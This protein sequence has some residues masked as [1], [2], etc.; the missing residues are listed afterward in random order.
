MIELAKV[1]QLEIQELILMTVYLL[2]LKQTCHPIVRIWVTENCQLFGNV[3]DE[4]LVGGE[5]KNEFFIMIL[6]LW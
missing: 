6:A 4:G 2:A 3:L 5:Y 1:L